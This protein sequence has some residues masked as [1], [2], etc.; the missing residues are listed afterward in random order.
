MTP[1]LMGRCSGDPNTHG[2]G[3]AV[4][5][6]NTHSEGA[7]VLLRSLIHSALTWALGGSSNPIPSSETQGQRCESCTLFIVLEAQTWAQGAW[8][9]GFLVLPLFCSSGRTQL[10]THGLFPAGTERHPGVR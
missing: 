5:T 4:T 3:A 9:V 10:L 2:K 1:T 7:V 6:P 8:A